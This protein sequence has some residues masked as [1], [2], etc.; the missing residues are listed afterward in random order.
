[1]K[2]YSAKFSY[3]LDVVADEAGQERIEANL[4]SFGATNIKIQFKPW[5]GAGAHEFVSAKIPGLED[6]E[7]CI[8]CLKTRETSLEHCP[9]IA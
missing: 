4:R 9:G 7:V 5:T 8:K 3:D 6:R 2:R 1:M